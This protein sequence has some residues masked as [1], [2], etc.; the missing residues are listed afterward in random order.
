MYNLFIYLFN[1]ITVPYP[2]LLSYS[3]SL[4]LLILGRFLSP[5]YIVSMLDIQSTG[6]LCILPLS[7]YLSPPAQVS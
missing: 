1:C 6:M 4:N 2:T 7:L 3:H 5:A